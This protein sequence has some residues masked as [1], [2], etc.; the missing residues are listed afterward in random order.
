MG[1]RYRIRSERGELGMTEP[2]RRAHPTPHLSRGT[3]SGD[4]RGHCAMQG[5]R[6]QVTLL[7]FMCCADVLPLLTAPGFSLW[8]ETQPLMP[9]LHAPRTLSPGSHP[10]NNP[11]SR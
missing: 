10:Q 2:G 11:I 9:S 8:L 4:R 1:L 7:W 6:Q 3:E 5:R